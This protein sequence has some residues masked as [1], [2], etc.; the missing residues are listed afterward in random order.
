MKIL[1]AACWGDNVSLKILYK[2]LVDFEQL[3]S[4]WKDFEAQ[5]PAELKNEFSKDGM[6]FLQRNLR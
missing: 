2:K 5:K 4:V 1:I 6:L 3:N